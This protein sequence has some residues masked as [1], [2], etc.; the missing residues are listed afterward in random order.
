M[1]IFNSKN[2]LIILLIAVAVA[3]TGCN[4]N[5]DY[6]VKNAKLAEVETIIKDFAGLSGYPITY[7]D[8]ATGAYR[9]VVQK[10]LVPVTGDMH[11]RHQAL[12]SQV[13]SLAVQMSQQGADVLINAQST[14]QLDASNQYSAFLDYLRGKGYTVQEVKQ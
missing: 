14:G 6:L 12:E 13:A 10:A 11:E 4:F 5:N 3:M 9:I 1:K 7:S 8:D 2:L